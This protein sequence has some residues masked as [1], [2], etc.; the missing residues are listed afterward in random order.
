MN[1]VFKVGCALL[2]FWAAPVAAQTSLPALPGEEEGGVFLPPLPGEEVDVTAQVNPPSVPDVSVVANDGPGEPPSEVVVAPISD[3]DFDS[4]FDERPENN[5]AGDRPSTV[6]ENDA[7]GVPDDQDG[8][9]SEFDGLPPL[10]GPAE[11]EVALPPLDEALPPIVEESTEQ[12]Q[13]EESGLETASKQIEIKEE[14]E[15]DVPKST[16]RYKARN[17][18]YKTQR[19]P[20]EIYKRQYDGKNRHLPRRMVDADYRHAYFVAAGRDDVNG[21]RAMLNAGYP[22]DRQDVWGDTALMVAAKSGAVNVV[23]YLLARGANAQIENKHGQTV[24][25]IAN[26]NRNRGIL[27]ALHSAGYMQNSR[28]NSAK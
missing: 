24:M 18:S 25:T 8:Q 20:E 15:K 17:F 23:R 19:L 16:R 5:V 11:E 2:V 10:D 21:V 27:A 4:F 13:R 12:P 6:S 22:V 26:S 7:L 9:V 28:L 1:S 3:D 14:K